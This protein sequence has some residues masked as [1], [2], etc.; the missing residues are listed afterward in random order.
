MACD[1]LLQQTAGINKGKTLRLTD[2]NYVHLIST[3]LFIEH[4]DIYMHLNQSAMD[5]K[6]EKG[7][8]ESLNLPVE[9]V[10][11]VF[12]RKGFDGF[13]YYVFSHCLS[14]LSVDD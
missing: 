4:S 11:F 5:E 1:L 2:L 6:L 10:Y 12:L 14:F 9:C 8:V 3:S 13:P 7:K